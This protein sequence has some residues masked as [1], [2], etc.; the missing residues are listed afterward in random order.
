MVIDRIDRIRRD[1]GFLTI[2]ELLDLSKNKNVILDPFSTLISKDVV[3]GSGNVFYPNVLI[4]T[5]HGGTIIIG[6]NNQFG[7]GGV[8]VKANYPDTK[9]IINN[10]CRLLNGVQVLGNTNLGSGCQV[11]G[12]QLTVLNCTLEAGGDYKS[13]DPDER[14]GV[15]K[16]YGRVVDLVIDRGKVANVEGKFDQS[17]IQNQS[18]YH[19][20]K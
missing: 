9:I 2:S 13:A 19:K 3:I 5:G 20:T 1:L 4:E 16:G 18:E 15:I 17:M 7:D 6:D 11:I 14:A 8:S 10:D 12:G